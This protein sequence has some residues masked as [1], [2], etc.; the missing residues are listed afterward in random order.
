[1]VPRMPEGP[2]GLEHGCCECDQ[3]MDWTSV[4]EHLFEVISERVGQVAYSVLVEIVQLV[5]TIRG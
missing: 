4:V 3:T 1:M 5:E 2:E